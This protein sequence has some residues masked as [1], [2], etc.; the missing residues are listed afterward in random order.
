MIRCV[1]ILLTFWLA[2]TAQGE[3]LVTPA[4]YV[5]SQPKPNF[6]EG[7][8]LPLLTRFGWT[9]PLDLRKELA[10]NWG[11]AMELSG[12]VTEKIVKKLQ[13]PKSIES[14]VIELAKQHPDKYKIAVILSRKLPFKEAPKEAWTQDKDGKLLNAKAMSIDGNVWQHDSDLIWSPEA[15]DSVWQLAAKYRVDP[16]SEIRKH[17]PVHIVLNGGEYG[18]GVLGFAQKAWELDPRVIKSKGDT[19]WYSYISQ[20][21]THSEMIIKN[22]VM[23]DAQSDSK[24]IFYVT[25]GGKMRN[26]NKQNKRWSWDY[27]YFRTTSDY[28]SD[29]YYFKLWNSG[30]SGHS[31]LLTQALNTKGHEFSYGDKN[32]YDWVSGGWPQK[33]KENTVSDNA[34]YEGFLKCIYMAGTLGANA[35]CYYF[36]EGGLKASFDPKNPPHWLSQMLALGKVHATYSNLDDWLLKGELL[37]GPEKHKWSK[38]QPAYEFPNSQKGV[39]ILARKMNDEFIVVAWDASGQSRT[40]QFT[41]TGIGPINLKATP[42]GALYSVKKVDGEIKI[43]PL[44]QE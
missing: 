15:P 2:I 9:L 22:A 4:E 20:R 23:K 13:N 43:N 25:G 44:N 14:Q 36:P 39:R 18:L 38:E 35:G 41:L 37:P 29:E 30:W 42:N 40:S 26:H 24:Y 5:Q 1:F 34:L 31:D 28:P 8:K 12:Y 10:E 7:H 3:T 16:L 21:K 17:V 6:K 19:D 11:Y 27:K 32:S 33:G